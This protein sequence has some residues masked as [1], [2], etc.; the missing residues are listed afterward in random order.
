MQK[1]LIVTPSESLATQ[2]SSLNKRLGLLTVVARDGAKGIEKYWQNQDISLIICDI[3]LP[4][5]DGLEMLKRIKRLGFATSSI[6]L[7]EGLEDDLLVEAKLLGASGWIMKPVTEKAYTLCIT[8][9]LGLEK[10]D[11]EASLP[12]KESDQ[13]QTL[14]N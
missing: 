2:M 4:V 12:K 5:I 1:I 6:V 7:T 8:Q 13:G 3:H 9:V 11:C 14:I 10:K